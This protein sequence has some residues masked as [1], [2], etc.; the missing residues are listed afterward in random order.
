MRSDADLP[1]TFPVGDFE[2]PTGAMAVVMRVGGAP[3]TVI[4]W[5][6]S[7]ADVPPLLHEVAD[8]LAEIVRARGVPGGG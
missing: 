3:L 2:V 4:G 8:A 6:A 1:P 7:P 5:A